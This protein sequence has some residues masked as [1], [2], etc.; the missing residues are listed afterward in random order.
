MR[1]DEKILLAEMA[2]QLMSNPVLRSALNKVEER[3]MADALAVKWY[4]PGADRRR[5]LALERV[6]IVKQ[7]RSQIESII[8]GGKNAAK[9]PPGVA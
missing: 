1:P 2:R 4:L 7:V 6:Q 3:A 9:P 8:S 5:R